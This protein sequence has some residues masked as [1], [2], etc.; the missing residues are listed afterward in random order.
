[1][2]DNPIAQ[3]DTYTVAEDGQLVVAAA[4]GV[5]KNDSDPDGE[6]PTAVKLSDPASGQ[7]TMS[8]DGSFKYVPAANFNGSVKFTYKVVAGSRESAP[9]TVTINVTA[10]NDAPVAYPDTYTLDEDTHV[11][12]AALDGVLGNDKDVDTQVLTAV[13]VHGP[14]HGQLTLNPDGS[15]SYQPSPNFNGT[16]TFTY[17]ANDGSALSDEVSVTLVVRPV[18]DPIGVSPVEDQQSLAGSPVAFTIVATDPDT[19]NQQFLYSLGSGAPAGA[20]IDAQTGQVSWLVPADASGEFDIPVIVEAGGRTAEQVVRV[21]VLNLGGVVFSTA[22]LA[23]AVADVAPA[24]QPAVNQQLLAAS[25]LTL[26]YNPLPPIELDNVDPPSPLDRIQS[27]D[28]VV[29]DGEVPEDLRTNQQNSGGGGRQR[30]QRP[31][32][33]PQTPAKGASLPQGS[34]NQQ[35]QRQANLRDATEAA[36]LALM[37]QSIE[38]AANRVQQPAAAP[39]SA[40]SAAALA[41]ATSPAAEPAQVSAS[42]LPLALAALASAD[43]ARLESDRRR[44]SRRARIDQGRTSLGR[45]CRIE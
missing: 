13:L 33:P 3:A 26:E 35:G 23:N 20:T 9:V 12:P 10:V 25:L 39:A 6:S 42:A 30:V 5:L 14:S 45:W 36:K 28:Y 44:P 16:D 7:L 4:N 15:F 32:T 17:R 8:P 24:S 38:A 37:L 34:S 41:E 18:E 22:Q 19:P 31:V 27:G 29:E 43:V 21:S 40:L 1:L 11:A 2:P